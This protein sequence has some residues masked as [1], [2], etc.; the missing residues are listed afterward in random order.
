[1]IGKLRKQDMRATVFSFAVGLIFTQNATLRQPIFCSLF[2]HFSRTRSCYNQRNARSRL[3]ASQE[4]ATHRPKE[5]KDLMLLPLKRVKKKR[6]TRRNLTA[7]PRKNKTRVKRFSF[8]C[9]RLQP[10]S[11]NITLHIGKLSSCKTEY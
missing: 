4:R 7:L 11:P 8:L 9:F 10:L 5:C 6:A 2:A 1:M 3:G